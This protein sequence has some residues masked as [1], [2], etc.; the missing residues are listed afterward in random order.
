MGRMRSVVVDPARRLAHVQPGCRLGDVDDATQ[1][2]GLA[3]VLGSDADTGVA[4]L[5]L[6]GGFGYLSRRFGWAV[7]NL[8]EAEVV[9]A[10]GELVRASDDEH[11][12]LFWALRGG[13]GNFGVVT[14]FTFR[15]HQVGP[16]IIGG[17]MIWDG[18]EAERVLA[19]YREV[20]EHAPR[21]LT[22]VTSMRLG[23]DAAIVPAHLRGKPVIGM[24]V[25]HTG[26]PARA[27]RDIAPLRESK[28]IVDTVTSK[29]YVEQQ[30]VLGLPQPRGMHQYW[31]SEFLAEL[32][33]GLLDA[34]RVHGGA[35]DSPLSQL[36]LFHLG[37]AVGDRPM[38]A[39]A[40]GN[41]DARYTFFAAG[42]WL[43]GQAPESHIGW[44]RDTWTALQLY[45]TGGNYVNAQ[46]ADDE[47]GRLED[48]YRDSFARLTEVK[49]AYDP[50]NF[51]RSNRNISPAG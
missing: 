1:A 17:M 43:P 47:E 36:V 15:L 51:F 50:G 25:C 22:L 11:A 42:T 14:R 35:L 40:M 41:R 3:T 32:D 19:L 2:H 16:R 18:A 4:G 33:D 20:T 26:D 23:A 7:D 38:D 5:T 28:P 10:D 31:K 39:T 6:G 8:V 37:G 24:L 45:S 13:G 34:F 27:Q 9:T 49:A 30:F 46:N 48:A 44:V 29:T 12:D 21:A